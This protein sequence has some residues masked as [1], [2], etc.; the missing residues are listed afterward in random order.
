MITAGFG[1]RGAATV[2]SLRDALAE[3]AGDRAPQAIAAPA[4]KCDA[5]AFAAFAAEL[6]LPV[7]PVPA[8]ALEQPETLTHS[9]RVQ[10]KRG[11]G[12]VAEAAALVAAGPGA[13]L[14]AA[15]SVSPDHMATC[16]LAESPET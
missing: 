13:R 10:A 16:A 12:S 2:Q 6:G 9:L 3:A 1:F 4:D 8:E 14:L 11:T 15:R 5:P 7:T